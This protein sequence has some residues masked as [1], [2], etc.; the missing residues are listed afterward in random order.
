M[1]KHIC[2]NLLS[3]FILCGL[4]TVHGDVPAL[5]LAAWAARLQQPSDRPARI[6]ADLCH[7]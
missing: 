5:A 6:L 3:A 2:F 4:W 1:I 7:G